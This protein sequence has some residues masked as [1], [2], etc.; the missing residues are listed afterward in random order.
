M[1]Q[2]IDTII[3]RVSDFQKS[4]AWFQ[5]K[6]GLIPVYENQEIKLIV[7]DTGSA[8]SITLWQTD[9]PI[10]INSTTASYPIFRTENAGQS[11]TEL[12]Q[13]GV[14]TTELITDS[15]VTYFQFFDPDGNVLEACQVHP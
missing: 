3:L 7:L 8:T 15:F 5:E 14:K 9:E 4:G 2:G 12:I 13:K 11:R 1:F 10:N 6:L